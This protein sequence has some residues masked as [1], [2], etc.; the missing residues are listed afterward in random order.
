MKA[1]FSVKLAAAVI[2]LF[3]IVLGFMVAYRPLK[4]RFLWRDLNSKDAAVR[5]K[6]A[7]KMASEGKKAVPYLREWLES[8]DPHQINTALFVA[9]ELPGKLWRSLIPQIGEVLDGPPSE[10][11]DTAADFL[12]DK[13]FAW[14]TRY[15][16]KTARLRNMYCHTLRY[17]RDKWVL[18]N[19]AADLGELGDR[20]AVGRLRET[21]KKN[22]DHDVA[23]A[24]AIAL[25][26]L[27]DGI[28]PEWFITVFVESASLEFR[29]RIMNFFKLMPADFPAC[30]ARVDKETRRKQAVMMNIWLSQNGDRLAWDVETERYYLKGKP[31][32]REKPQ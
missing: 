17:S 12:E 13:A 9:D 11:T 27:K 5:A 31:A 6:A 20:L 3:V 23:L 2:W 10:I 30:D 25:A 21:L 26:R 1:G 19:A 32:A 22:R 16:G 29:T 18:Y 24:A 7:K 4:Y 8:G 28:S 15:A 14:N